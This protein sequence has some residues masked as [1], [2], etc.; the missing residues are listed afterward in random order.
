MLSTSLHVGRRE[1]FFLSVAAQHRCETQS[2]EV[3]RLAITREKKE[4]FVE[5]YVEQLSQSQAVV[6]SEYRGITVQ[7]IQKLRGVMREHNRCV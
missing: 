7:Q 4:E 6:L 5:S 3:K 1:G 2:K